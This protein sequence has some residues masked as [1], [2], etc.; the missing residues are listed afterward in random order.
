MASNTDTYEVLT[1][2]SSIPFAIE[3]SLEE[4]EELD[5]ALNV[6]EKLSAPT[7]QASG[8]SQ[9]R[10]NPGSPSLQSLRTT[11]A[12]MLGDQYPKTKKEA[13]KI[14]KDIFPK[15]EWGNVMPQINDIFSQIETQVV[16]TFCENVA[17]SLTKEFREKYQEFVNKGH[18]AQIIASRWGRFKSAIDI[19]S[20]DRVRF[21]DL[22]DSNQTFIMTLL[23][24]TSAL[25][26]IQSKD[27]I[28]E[29]P[30][31]KYCE[32]LTLFPNEIALTKI[33]T[34]L[35]KG[36]L[37]PDFEFIGGHYAP[38]FIHTLNVA[39]EL[40]PKLTW[41]SSSIQSSAYDI[42]SNT[43]TILTQD[44]LKSICQDIQSQMTT[45]SLKVAL[46]ILA[47]KHDSTKQMRNEKVKA[48]F[49]GFD[50]ISSP[51]E[52]DSFTPV[53]IIM[54]FTQILTKD[55]TVFENLLASSITNV[56][57]TKK[58]IDIIV[59]KLRIPAG[60]QPLLAYE[61]ATLSTVNE[62]SYFDWA[63]DLIQAF[64][65]AKI[66][67]MN[68][69]FAK[70][71]VNRTRALRDDNFELFE[72][73]IPKLIEVLGKIPN[74]VDTKNHPF[75]DDFDTKKFSYKKNVGHGNVG[76]SSPIEASFTKKALDA[77]NKANL[78]TALEAIFGTSKKVDIKDP[79]QAI[80]IM[81]SKFVNNTVTKNMAFTKLADPHVENCEVYLTSKYNPLNLVL[82][83]ERFWNC[84][85]TALREANSA[86]LSAFFDDAY[87]FVTSFLFDYPG[88]KAP[89]G[90]SCGA[91]TSLVKTESIL[92]DPESKPIQDIL[93]FPKD[94]SLHMGSSQISLIYKDANSNTNSIALHNDVKSKIVGYT[95][96]GI[97]VTRT[98]FIGLS[99]GSEGTAYS[100][101]A[102]KALG[103]AVSS[104]PFLLNVCVGAPE[105]GGKNEELSKG[106][107][108]NLFFTKDIDTNF[109]IQIQ[110]ERLYTEAYAEITREVSAANAIFGIQTIINASAF[111]NALHIYFD[112]FE[113]DEF[114]LVYVT[115]S[116][117]QKSITLQGKNARSHLQYM[118]SFPKGEHFIPF[119]G[120]VHFH[121]PLQNQS[122]CKEL[123]IPS[124]F[125]NPKPLV[126]NDVELYTRDL[127]AMR[128]PRAGAFIHANGRQSRIL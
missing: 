8:Y 17:Q 35:G 36:E 76:N 7:S 41:C 58:A 16:T 15:N 50:Y 126:R 90:I 69:D 40:D 101:H 52:L 51:E 84:C 70:G 124:W 22:S 1:N 24:G 67:S 92:V 94:L 46:S 73:E 125:N 32:A 98:S 49:Q 128:T 107:S 95:F 4:A 5:I 29:F 39:T 103:V 62:R 64:V 80:F 59:S 110:K 13:A 33:M 81:A 87:A 44:E 2:T 23:L 91:L 63:F 9:I 43:S 26:N 34:V 28:S 105:S 18:I 120:E 104:T 42:V 88:V 115:K 93:S 66:T 86:T 60:A 57:T 112:A 83:L 111:A 37:R 21:D 99:D 75:N 74:V 78:T 6:L 53:A 122:L 45:A 106:F 117:D 116:G 100:A 11:L 56:P 47:K 77:V 20:V 12:N 25:L 72:L 19:D 54:Y 113:D 127:I 68:S 27:E 85:L 109:G 96:G 79:I 14:A 123:L 82:G 97:E 3:L 102:K 108:E 118:F 119:R 31:T 38:A 10:R 30:I 61:Y 89:Q 121:T 71:I 114:D 65:E 55:I 48:I